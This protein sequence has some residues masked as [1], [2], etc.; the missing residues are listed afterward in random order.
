EQ[1]TVTPGPRERPNEGNPAEKSLHSPVLGHAV[2]RS[3]HW[4]P[5]GTEALGPRI[6]E[7][8]RE[9]VSRVAGSPPC[10]GGGPCASNRPSIL[11]RGGRKL[12]WC[13]WPEGGQ[14]AWPRVA[15]Q[16]LLLPSVHRRR[17]AGEPGRL[18]GQ[19]TA[20]SRRPI[21]AGSR[22]SAAAG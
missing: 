19:L 2:R 13:V 22:A 8:F 15:R 7:Y 5:R 16:N 1:R 12:S 3:G 14:R 20:P 9:R 10:S 4:S 6:R 18:G 21:P 17:H 11:S